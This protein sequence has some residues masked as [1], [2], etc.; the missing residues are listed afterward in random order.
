V[1]G[2]SSTAGGARRGTSVQCSPHQCGGTA[3]AQR[4]VVVDGELHMTDEVAGA[5]GHTVTLVG[6]FTCGWRHSMMAKP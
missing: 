2:W 4:E 3:R 6:G 1:D 5:G